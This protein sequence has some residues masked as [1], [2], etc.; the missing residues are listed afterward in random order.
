MNFLNSF[1]KKKVLITGHTGFKGSWLTMWL[2]KYGAEIIGYSLK[3]PTTPSL[4]EICKL[5]DKIVSIEGDIRDYETLSN[6]FKKYKP[7][8]VFHLAA[9]PLVKRSYMEPA[10]TYETNIMGT[11][12]V[13]E[14]SR[15]TESVKV[16][17]VVTSDKCYENKEWVYAYRETDSLGGV[18]PYSSSKACAELIVSAYRASYFKKSK[19]GVASV[20]AGNVIGGGDWAED[21]LMPDIIRA[22][23][24]NKPLQIRNPN[25]TRPWQFVLEPLLGYLKLAHLL[26]K[27]PEKYSEA[28]NFG[29]LSFRLL[30]VIDIVEEVKKYWNNLEVKIEK[31]N[32]FQ[33][34]NVLKLDISK[35]I[36][37]L[38]WYPVYDIYTSI[39]ETI[40]WYK[41]FYFKE[42]EDMFEY[43]L[44]QIKK[45]EEYAKKY[46]E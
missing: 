29:P 15:L 44:T 42:T 10:Y 14:A 4:F 20:R 6:V 30:K 45:Y 23:M 28:W 34:A 41:A 40:E 1:S 22:I 24:H 18:D 8:I 2:L 21:R 12:N 37:K 25:A 16:I 46:L 31:E 32:S 33:E 3:P 26:Q 35:S 19:V 43:S 36:E 7:E 27:E 9:Q 13:L 5:R 39:K 38:N 11:V 17:V